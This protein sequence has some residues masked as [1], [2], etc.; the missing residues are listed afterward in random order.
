M[1]RV[2]PIYAKRCLLHQRTQQ[3]AAKWVTNTD[4]SP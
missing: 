1:P 2:S 4:E 3:L